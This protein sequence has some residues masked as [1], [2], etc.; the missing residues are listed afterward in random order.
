MKNKRIQVFNRTNGS[1]G[2]RIPSTGQVRTWKRP[3]DYLN[4]SVGELLELKTAP[5]G[6][7]MLE[8]NLLIKDEEALQVI[9]PDGDLE[10]EYHY[11]QDEI[12]TLLYEATNEQLLDALDYAP[13]G[14]L[15]LIKMTAVNKLPNATDKIES[16][17]ERFNIDLVQMHE[18]S[19]EKGE[20]KVENNTR[21]RKRRT[22]P[23]IGES[24]YK[25]ISREGE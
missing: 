5:G 17:N 25:V 11:T 3:G 14:V 8:K 7:G 9:F 15:E 21:P 1:I 18:I 2:Y 20:I 24:K 12:N 23:L 22:K 4:I 16:I 6:R 13:K 10:P 19:K